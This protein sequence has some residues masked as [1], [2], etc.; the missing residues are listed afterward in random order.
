MGMRHD[1][2]PVMTLGGRH[3][4]IMVVL[5]LLCTNLR[6]A[7]AWKKMMPS[8]AVPLGNQRA[9]RDGDKKDDDT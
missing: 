5:E 6:G 7:G 2:P 4:L 3:L 9:G 1:T 8:G